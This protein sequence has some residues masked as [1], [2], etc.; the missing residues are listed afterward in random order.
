MK[1]KSK[2]AYEA[3]KFKK[4]LLY[5]RIIEAAEFDTACLTS[6]VRERADFE[7]SF[8]RSLEDLS[9]RIFLNG[10]FDKS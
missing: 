7:K 2:D 9:L 8:E 10:V 6:T 5:N 4:P 1:D 3:L